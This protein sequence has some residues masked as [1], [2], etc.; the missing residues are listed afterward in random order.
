M[1]RHLFGAGPASWTFNNTGSGTPMVGGAIVQAFNAQVG[2]T[3]YTDL[4]LDPDGSLIVDHVTSSDASDGLQLG[5]IPPFY[6]PDGVYA[7]WLSANGG[8]RVYTVASDLGDSV[9]N[10]AGA[11]QSAQDDLDA[12]ED[13]LGQPNGIATL[14]A[15]GKLNPSQR[16]TPQ[17]SIANASDASV[18]GAQNGDLLVYNS[19]SSK[20]ELNH[21]TSWQTLT[22]ASGYTA[23]TTTPRYRK[24]RDGRFLYLTGQLQKTAGGGI[25]SGSTVCTLPVGF[26]PTVGQSIPAPAQL[27]TYTSVRADFHT[28][29]T[30]VIFMGYSPT[31]VGFDGLVVALD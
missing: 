31:W 16:W 5:Q 26:R 21:E 3:Q 10:N 18:S 24:S 14:G 11:I 2:G 27:N 8:P 23:F 20:W 30:V 17:F 6:G 19:S 28:D 15:D 1:T 13:T 12:L 22:L 25:S 9:L 29:G 4:S 7:M